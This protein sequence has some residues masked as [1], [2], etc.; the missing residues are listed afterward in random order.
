M[1]LAGPCKGQKVF[2]RT[3]F[4]KL[5]HLK[6]QFSL[7]K[8]SLIYNNNINHKVKNQVISHEGETSLL[9]GKGRLN[10]HNAALTWV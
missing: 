10:A 6:I 7:Y 2:T 5:V 4:L 3:K 9:P 8:N 1:G